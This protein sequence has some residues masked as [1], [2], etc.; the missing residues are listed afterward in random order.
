MKITR[1][2]F[3]TS[4]AFETFKRMPNLTQEDALSWI[5]NQPE[6]LSYLFNKARGSGAISKDQ[7]G[8]WVG[9]EAS[10]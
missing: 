9:T 1:S 4:K 10:L 8:N 6:F 2:S 7:A 3:R 5:A